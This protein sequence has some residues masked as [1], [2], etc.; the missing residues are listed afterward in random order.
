[1]I[2][3]DNP[4]VNKRQ[5]RRAAKQVAKKQNDKPSDE[6]TGAKRKR[7]QDARHDKPNS[8][9]IELE[10]RPLK[11]LR[12]AL[13]ATAKEVTPTPEEKPV[14]SQAARTAKTAKKYGKK[15][16]TS[17]PV[18]ASAADI[19][20]DELPDAS[21]VAHGLTS[22]APRARDV[23]AKKKAPTAT[24]TKARTAAKRA[25]RRP[26]PPR[27]PRAKETERPVVK[28]AEHQQPQ[29]DIAND[30]ASSSPPPARELKPRE[31]KKKAAIV[32]IPSVSPQRM[33][34]AG[35]LWNFNRRTISR[36][37]LRRRRPK[38]N[39]WLVPKR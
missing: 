18:P 37:L 6:P 14:F 30:E 7:G 29:D 10:R 9:D 21:S 26:V 17:S 36:S 38:R 22:P 15:G 24:S 25:Q 2:C 27:K 16:R 12:G 34:Y 3:P 32:D 19:D 28:N 35:A 23:K 1:M 5:P 11:R 20:Y 8:D 39:R 33:F 13:P 31:A 4:P